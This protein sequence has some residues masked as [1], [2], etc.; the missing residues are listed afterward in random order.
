MKSLLCG[1]VFLV[2]FVTEQSIAWERQQ[3][4]MAKDYAAQEIAEHYRLP[5][6][7]VREIVSEVYEAS[8]EY[9]VPADVIL[10]VIAT[11]SSY[12][13]DAISS[14]GALGLMQVRPEYWGDQFDLYENNIRAGAYILAKYRDR[15]GGYKCMLHSYNVG[16]TGY[17][18]G[19]RNQDYLDKVNAFRHQFNYL[20]VR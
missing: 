6:G 1:L 7:D 9:D 13:K 16:I 17:M 3:M 4:V 18:R 14:V 12:N 19:S 11:E 15:C 10:A 8:R 2:C 20:T 5:Y